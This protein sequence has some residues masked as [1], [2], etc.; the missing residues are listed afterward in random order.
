LVKNSLKN[1][2]TNFKGHAIIRPGKKTRST[3]MYYRFQYG[4]Y[5]LEE[6]QEYVSQ[7]G[8]ED[9]LNPEG[10]C[11]CESALE[12]RRNTVYTCSDAGD[13]EIVLMRGV[14]LERI[15]DGVRIFP[16]EIVERFTPSEF[17]ANLQ[18]I[19]EKYE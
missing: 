5:S 9:S 4:H 13:A 15:Y 19:I 2:L 6:M 14:L 17:E 18:Q 10:I 7:D 11:A 12:L 16:T 1:P 3:E 8:A